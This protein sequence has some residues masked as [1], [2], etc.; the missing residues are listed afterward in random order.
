MDYSDEF[1]VLWKMFGMTDKSGL[2][3]RGSKYKAWLEWKKI[4]KDNERQW[5]ELIGQKVIDQIN[6]K[7]ALKSKNQFFE[8]F[9]HLERY[10]KNRRWEDEDE[11]GI[12]SEALPEP[13]IQEQVQERKR[14]LMSRDW[15]G[16]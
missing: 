6:D 3:K 2:G 15:Y 1:E 9:Q 8:S 11:A 7:M 16:R 13:D 12:Q 14:Q 4:A 10:L 5:L